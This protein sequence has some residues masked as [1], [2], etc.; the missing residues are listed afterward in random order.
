M[1]SP[2]QPVEQWRAASQ[3]AISDGELV[4]VRELTKLIFVFYIVRE[5]QRN[6][7]QGLMMEDACR[8]CILQPENL[9]LLFYI[10]RYSP[11]TTEPNVFVIHLE[12]TRFARDP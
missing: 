8:S 3:P 1:V 7:R 12:P 9:I 10:E 2:R 6:L 11:K 4:K 5:I